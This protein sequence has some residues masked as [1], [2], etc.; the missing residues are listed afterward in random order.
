[1]MVSLRTG[2]APFGR[3][4][5]TPSPPRG[6]MVASGA[7]ERRRS[8]KG[9]RRARARLLRRDDATCLVARVTDEICRVV[10]EHLQSDWKRWKVRMIGQTR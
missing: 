3:R 9:P 5:P 6:A 1:M 4:E 7:V 2:A 10:C 8:Q